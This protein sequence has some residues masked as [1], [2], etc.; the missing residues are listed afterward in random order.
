MS[1]AM[2]VPTGLRVAGREEGRGMLAR[3]PTN[4]FWSR[5]GRR[6]RSDGARRPKAI[7]RLKSVHE[8]SRSALTA[9]TGLGAMRVNCM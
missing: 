6:A 9:T 4:G 1:S 5:A 2:P 3:Q 7:Q 8:H